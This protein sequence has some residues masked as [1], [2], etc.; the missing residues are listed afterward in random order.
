MIVH[1][2]ED[3]TIAQSMKTFV[4]IDVYVM[5]CHLLLTLLDLL[6]PILIRNPTPIPFGNPCPLKEECILT[7]IDFKT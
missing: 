7:M 3:Q 2:C 5:M 4:V 1:V 6:S